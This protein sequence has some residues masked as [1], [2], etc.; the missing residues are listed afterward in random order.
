MAEQVGWIP[1][2]ECRKRAK[3]MEDKRGKMYTDCSDCGV[4]KYQTNKGQETIR[5]RFATEGEPL[6]VGGSPVV[7]PPEKPEPKPE[8]PAQAEPLQD[9]KP[10][11]FFG[12]LFSSKPPWERAK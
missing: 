7:E 12:N 10:R 2:A 11:G 4:N 6:E 1:C 8:P 9:Q 3:A 5:A